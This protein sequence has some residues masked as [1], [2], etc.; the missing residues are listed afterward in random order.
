VNAYTSISGGLSFTPQYDDNGNMLNDDKHTYAYDFNN[1][2]VS[3]DETVGTYKYDA[4]GR[5]IAKNNTLFYY[6]CDQMVEEVT[7][8][9]T[10]SYLYGNEIDEALQMKRGNSTYYYHTNHL[11]STMAISDADGNNIETVTYDAYGIPSI[12][13]ETGNDYTYSSIGN[14][15]LFTGREYDTEVGIYNFRT[16][17]Q[18]PHMGRFIQKD[19]ITFYN[20][21]NDMGYVINNPVVNRDPTGL[22]YIFINGVARP[23][24]Q[25]ATR[26]AAQQAGKQVAKGTVQEAID[27]TTNEAVKAQAGQYAANYGKAAANGAKN[28]TGGS[29]FG[30][31]GNGGS[32]IA[33]DGSY[34][35]PGAG[36]QVGGFVG[37]LIGGA[38]AG[39]AAGAVF[40][41]VGAVPGFFI[42]LG[43]GLIGGW[44][45]GEMGKGLDN[46][47]D[48]NHPHNPN[49]TSCDSPSDPPCYYD[50]STGT[51]YCGISN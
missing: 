30:N 12:N 49:P 34:K 35:G 6:V 19:P 46:W 3:V 17:Y 47:W 26:Q 50:S 42:G 31:L 10:T 48:K 20:G 16:R 21:M 41:G 9:V 7:D 13:Y 40:G 43:G 8:G 28:S 38:L 39:A 27:L 44:I 11:G 4:L 36:E 22:Y 1:K 45:G 2:L 15:I 18:H 23:L 37:G 33:D 51:I 29:V 25:Q 5:R 32:V 24:V 14:T